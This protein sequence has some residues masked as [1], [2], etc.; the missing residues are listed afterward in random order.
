MG[1]LV[2]VSS[3]DDEGIGVWDWVALGTYYYYDC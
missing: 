1:V 3:R 2:L